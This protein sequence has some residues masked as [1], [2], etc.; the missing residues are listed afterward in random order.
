MLKSIFS[1]EIKKIRDLCSQTTLEN[2]KISAKNTPMP[3]THQI[4]VTVRRGVKIQT[5][6]QEKDSHSN[7]GDPHGE[8]LETLIWGIT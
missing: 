7:Q 5:I 6:N 4:K 3:P 8:F 1:R 2:V